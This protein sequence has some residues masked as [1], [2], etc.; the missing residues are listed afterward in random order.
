MFN[1]WQETD[2]R[3]VR[4]LSRLVYGKDSKGSG[5]LYNPLMGREYKPNQYAVFVGL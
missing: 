5:R 2:E 1:T 4:I 3:S